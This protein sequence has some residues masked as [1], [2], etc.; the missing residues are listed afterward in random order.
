MGNLVVFFGRNRSILNIVSKYK[1]VYKASLYEIEIKEEISFLDKLLNKKIN[2]EKC[3]INLNNYENI[4]LVTS[5]WFNKI[6][7]PVI[8]FLEQST[9]KINNIIYVLYNN[10]KEDYPKEFDKMDRI[11]NLRRKNSYFVSIDKN[12]IHVRVY[13]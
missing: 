11:L 13:Q 2:I 3:N 5:L 10:N 8:R 9:G 7:S 6:P 12:D 1:N 4:I